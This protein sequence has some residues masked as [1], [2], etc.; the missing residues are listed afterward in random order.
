MKNSQREPT[1]IVIGAGIGGIAAAV[2]LACKGYDVDVFEASEGPGGKLKEISLDGYRFDAGPSLFT[3]PHLVEALFSLAGEKAS[4]HFRY[5]RLVTACHYFYPDGVFFKAP[6]QRSRFV[7]E[8]HRV[9]GVSRKRLDD[10]LTHCATLMDRT[11]RIFLEK[12]LHDPAT[13]LSK[14]VLPALA[15][16]P[17]TTLVGSM[18]KS[19]SQR[20]KEPH[21]V[22]LFNRYATYNGSDPYQAPGLLQ[23]IAA[24]EQ[25]QG[26]FFP[27]GGMY[28]ITEQLVGLAERLGVR[29]HYG[30]QV[31]R[32]R[33]ER[34]AVSG[35]VLAGGEEVRAPV[36]VSNMDVVPT[37]RRLL[38][39]VKAPGHVMRQERSS[40]ALIYYWGIEGVFP[41]LDVH[42]IFFSADYRREFDAIFRE[43]TI[44]DDPTVYVHISSK[45]ELADAPAGSENWFVMVNVPYN[46][47]QDWDALFA[48]TRE[49]VLEKVSA[50][51]GRHV[52]PLIA[53]E[54][55][56][57]PVLLE[58]R[59]FSHKGALYGASSNSRLAAFLRHPNKKSS[60]K[61]LYF[62]GGSVHP[63]GGVPLCLLSARIAD[64]YIPKRV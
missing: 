5:R 59:T 63:G 27:E 58:Q 2:R 11:G 41:E 50:R 29:F 57:D 48:S 10:Y 45:L 21:L 53:V 19:N 4:D 61:G 7:E 56:L 23:M 54:D 32:I 47:G 26:S 9:F 12:S 46:D 34:G 25:G 37:Y 24:L 60:I 62:V 13:W 18:D 36:V 14:D 16:L 35:V 22:Q 28:S 30:R 64:H 17:W 8:A 31:E 3:M 33:V 6:G 1:A 55:R 39:D 38:P 42:N 44:S 43:G 51:L 40:S 20:L 52:G 49:R 15:Y